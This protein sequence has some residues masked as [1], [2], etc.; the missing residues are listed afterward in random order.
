[1]IGRHCISPASL[2]FWFFSPSA[3]FLVRLG[4]VIPLFLVCLLL[5]V[6]IGLVAWRGKLHMAA[7]GGMTIG[8]A[9]AAILIGQLAGAQG[10]RG[11]TV[12]VF[13]SVVFFLFVAA[14]FGS[15]LG[16]LLYRRPREK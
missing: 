16:L 15:F 6:A 8:A 9:A 10:V 1:M 11:T 12:G 14:A 5:V 13:V 7:Y 2:G 3:A 4:I